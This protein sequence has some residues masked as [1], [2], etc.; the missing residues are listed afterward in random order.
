M[1]Q[2]MHSRIGQRPQRLGDRRTGAPEDFKLLRLE[3]LAPP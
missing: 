1:R 2:R 3:L